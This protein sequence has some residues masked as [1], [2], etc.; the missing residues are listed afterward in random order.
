MTSGE[1][2]GVLMMVAITL[3]EEE[4]SALLA[5]AIERR[6]QVIMDGGIDDPHWRAIVMKI[7]RARAEEVSWESAV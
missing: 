3:S 5:A 2:E 1:R 7:R 6:I 4:Q